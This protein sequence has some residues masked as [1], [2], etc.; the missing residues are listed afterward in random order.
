MVNKAKILVNKTNDKHYLKGRIKFKNINR[1]DR[2][3]DFSIFGLLP[4]RKHLAH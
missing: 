1:K 4:S 2:R 3:D